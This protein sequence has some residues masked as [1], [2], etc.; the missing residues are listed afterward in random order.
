MTERELDIIKSIQLNIMDEIHRIC[1][2]HNI[3]Y[4]LIGGTALGAVRHGGFIPWDVDI[5]IAMF[6]T[7]Y[8]RFKE[9]CRTELNGNY[10][11]L[12]YLSVEDYMRPHALICDRLS[13]IRMKYD[14]INKISE[15]HGIYVD[16]FPLD[17]APDEELLRI[18]QA[19]MLRRLAVLKKYRIPY[20]YST[21]WWKRFVRYTV[22]MMLSWISIRRINTWQ[23]NTMQLYRNQNTESI[24]SMASQYPYKKQC[25]PKEI[26]GTPVPVQ[27]EGRTYYAPEQSDSYLTRLY[28]DYMQLPPVERRQKNME[29]YSSVEFFTGVEK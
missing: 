12:D 7:E 11:Y 17:N 10:E 27:F 24:C 3:R 8:D 22:S 28:G 20:Y 14:P 29:I 2:E 15:D 25:M 1:V 23:Q 26:Y 19:K 16:V 21:K 18:K 6:R 9:V 5:D 13:K 4:Y